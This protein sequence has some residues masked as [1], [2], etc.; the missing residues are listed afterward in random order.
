[1]HLAEFYFRRKREERFAREMENKDKYRS[2]RGVPEPC[3]V[4][5]GEGVVCTIYPRKRCEFVP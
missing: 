1:V 5:R 4:P 3:M 2:S